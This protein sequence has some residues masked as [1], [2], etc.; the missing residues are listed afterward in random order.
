MRGCVP[1][2]IKNKALALLSA[3]FSP[4]LEDP[5]KRI[6]QER[7]ERMEKLVLFTDMWL[8]WQFWL[9]GICFVCDLTFL[10][11]PCWPR[12]YFI[13]QA[14]L[15]FVV[16]LL[17]THSKCW[18]NRCVPLHPDEGITTTRKPQGTAQRK[19]Q[20]S[21][22]SSKWFQQSCGLQLQKQVYS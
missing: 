10:C 11:S 20:H 4:E 5:A 3:L 21:V 6:R 7:L 16:I 14:G 12:G 19:L 1:L 2:K 17:P 8:C 9:V 22:R 15:K 18:G 13:N